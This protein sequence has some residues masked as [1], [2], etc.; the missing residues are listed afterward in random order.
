MKKLFIAMCVVVSFA[1]C[2]K[3]EKTGL[4]DVL[5]DRFKD[6]QD[7][8]DYN[9]D[10]QDIADC[11]VDEIAVSLPGFAGDPRRSQ[12]FDAYARFLNVKSES[13]AEKSVREFEQLFGGAQ[14]AREAATSITDHVMTCMGKGIENATPNGKRAPAAAVEQPAK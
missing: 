9:L 10:P 5:V 8:K 14:R 11:V 3:K 7:L 12:F 4:H 6:D 2:S 13:D 1:G